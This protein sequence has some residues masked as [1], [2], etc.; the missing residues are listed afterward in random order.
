MVTGIEQRLALAVGNTVD[1]VIGAARDLDAAAE[2]VT[3]VMKGGGRFIKPRFTGSWELTEMALVP[4]AARLRSAEQ[5]LSMA[6]DQGRVASAL[7]DELGP[8]PDD[9]VTQLDLVGARDLVSA[10][11]KERAGFTGL[12]TRDE[13]ASDYT[14]NLRGLHARVAD[15][16]TAAREFTRF[17]GGILQRSY[18]DALPAEIQAAKAIPGIPEGAE[19]LAN[20]DLFLPY[21]RPYAKQAADVARETALAISGAHENV[22]SSGRSVVAA[23]AQAE[24]LSKGTGTHLQPALSMLDARIDRTVEAVRREISTGNLALEAAIQQVKS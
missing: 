4:Y 8:I 10:H 15:L 9:V 21:S 2:L 14:R 11:V 20:H 5:T 6:V 19:R 7:L 24:L 16:S 18:G 13:P 22:T 1:L 23:L 12:L 3:P 17:P